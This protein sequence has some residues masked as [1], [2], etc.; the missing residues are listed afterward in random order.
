[1]PGASEEMCIYHIASEADW[2]K[3]TEDGAY[4]I[5]TRG[6]TL[7]EQG[8]IHA[9]DAEQVAPVANLI[10]RSDDGLIVLVIDVD[11]LHPEARYDSV[12]GSDRPFPHVYGPLNIDAVVATLPLDRGPDGRFAFSVTT[13]Q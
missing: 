3:A 9:D 12:P 11:R 10:Y 5:S 2:R 4:R 7:D 13:G 8:F 1:M 6:R